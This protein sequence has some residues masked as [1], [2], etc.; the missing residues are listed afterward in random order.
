VLGPYRSGTSITARILAE[1]GVEFGPRD[2]LVPADVRNPTGYFERNDLNTVNHAFIESAGG[3]L[4]SPGDPI[5]LA[6]AGDLEIL[7]GYDM[8]WSKT[9]RLAGIKDPRMCATLWSWLHCGKIPLNQVKVIC[10]KRDAAAIQSSSEKH[11]SV[12]GYADNDPDRIKKMVNRYIELTEWHRKHLDTPIY[13]FEYEQLTSQPTEVVKGL[14]SFLGVESPK[15]I[16]R[17]AAV[18]GSDRAK[19]NF[20][21]KSRWKHRWRHFKAKLKPTFLNNRSIHK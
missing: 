3:S 20:L 21:W 13:T 16:K 6:T 10:I 12:A 2:D 19:K 4:E 1:L 14:A 17:A 9:A 8:S 11:K 7:R 5:D 18:I 15:A